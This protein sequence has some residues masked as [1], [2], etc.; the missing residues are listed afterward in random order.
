MLDFAEARDLAI[1][2]YVAG[3]DTVC[4][5]TLVATSRIA[6]FGKAGPSSKNV[7]KHLFW[8]KIEISKIIAKKRN[9]PKFFDVFWFEER[10][11]KG[12][13]SGPRMSHFLKK[14][15]IW[16]LR[17]GTSD[18]SD[19]ITGSNCAS[20]EIDGLADVIEEVKHYSS[21]QENCQGV[22]PK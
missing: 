14:P 22:S 15:R 21:S 3:N 8:G 11:E 4:V 9:L 17:L 1:E 6:N 20:I 7:T 2:A 10:L 16:F 18:I 13:V 5:G 19:G 12:E